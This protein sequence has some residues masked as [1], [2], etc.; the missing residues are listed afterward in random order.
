MADSFPEEYIRQYFYQYAGYPKY[1]KT[2]NIYEGC[3]PFCHEGT[4]WGKKKRFYYLP[5]KDTVLCKNCGYYENGGKFVFDIS[6]LSWSEIYKESKEFD[7]IPQDL[8]HQFNNVTTA[9]V[10]TEILPKNPINLNNSTQLEYYKD[11]KT[12]QL[13]LEYIK[14]R[15]LD[16]C[17][18]KTDYYLSL[19]DFVH[20]NRLILPYYNYNNDIEFYQTR[21]LL[22]EN[23]PNYLSKANSEKILPN[24]SKISSDIPYI[25]VFEGYIDSLFVK[26]ATC[27]SGIQKDS[28][29]LFTKTQKD[30]LREF[31]FHNIIWVL[32]SQ[33][34][35]ETSRDKSK[36]LLENDQ[37]VFIWPEKY[38]KL[39]KDFNEM[40]V[41]LKQDEIPYDFIIKN[42]PKNNFEGLMKLNLIKF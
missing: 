13:A 1:K 27:C 41:K 31:M 35:D 12:L 14:S 11:N 25:F 39:F 15:R 30:Q 3:C 17:I 26:N 18:G 36:H 9:I 4:S 28:S 10:N 42:T 34:V 22:D 16:T 21:K 40:A 19:D 38:G 29:F 23:S 7:I 8:Q 2:T 33:Y 6:G 32:D 24:L 37:K 20:K 5:E